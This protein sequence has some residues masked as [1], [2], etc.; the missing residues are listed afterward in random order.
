M[1][2]FISRFI[3]F[4]IILIGFFTI[5]FIINFIIIAR[6]QLPL[7]ESNIIIAG[8]SHVKY[9]LNPDFFLSANNISQDSEPYYLT[10]IKLK[11]IIP[12]IHIDTLIVGFSI[13]NLTTKN[14]IKLVDKKW[15]TTMFVRT[16]ALFPYIF[17]L[18]GIKIDYNEFGNI[19]M[20]NM[21]FYPKFN[22]FNFIGNYTNLDE[23]HLNDADLVFR[24]HFYINDEKTDISKSALIYL[25]SI[26]NLSQKNNI[27]II[28]L[29]TPV[30]N[31]Y[32]SKIPDDIIQGYSFE[33]NK[34][35]ESGVLVIDYTDKFYTDKLYLN[36]DHLNEE[37]AKRFT[38]QIINLLKKDLTIK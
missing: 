34:I 25:D 7:K 13:H 38:Y 21:C 9:G 17:S 5:N 22:H 32:Y 23:T 11:Y 19:L 3:L 26:I 14:D 31:S 27:K 35:E 16:Y 18:N 10:Y 37:G 20:R 8:D 36:S 24:R 4:I 2:K 1:N 28:L 6:S 33:K 30:H 29:G 12:R 15:S